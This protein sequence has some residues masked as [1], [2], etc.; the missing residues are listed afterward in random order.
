M[1]NTNLRIIELNTQLILYANESTMLNIIDIGSSLKNSNGELDQKYHVGD[2]I[3][4]NPSGYSVFID[5]I[6][7]KLKSYGV[8]QLICQILS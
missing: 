2:G 4:L 8:W 3:H 5:T 6:N 7:K 1:V